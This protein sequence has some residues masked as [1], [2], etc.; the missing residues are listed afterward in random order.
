MRFVA[1]YARTDTPSPIMGIDMSR[2][3]EATLRAPSFFRQPRGPWTT[4]QP[5]CIL[6]GNRQKVPDGA[7]VE[8]FRG[9][10]LSTRGPWCWLGWKKWCSR[11]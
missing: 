10:K 8:T 7:W 2:R 6:D 9:V 4:F 1:L 3:L 11:R 5:C